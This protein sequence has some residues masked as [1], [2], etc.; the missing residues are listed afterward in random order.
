MTQ[1]STLREH[2]KAPGIGLTAYQATINLGISR[3]A[4]RIR[5]LE[6]EGY[7]FDH[8]TIKVASRHG[9][10]RVADYVLIALPG[11]SP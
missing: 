10:A 2:Y 8:N 6:A 9:G 1:L 3:L 11:V 4:E 7:K 5:E